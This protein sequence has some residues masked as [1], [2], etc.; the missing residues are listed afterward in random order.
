[1]TQREIHGISFTECPECSQ[2][3]GQ[4]GLARHREQAHGVAP[5]SKG[6]KPKALTTAAASM[7]RKAIELGTI[8]AADVLTTVAAPG[9]VRSGY[10][11]DNGDGSFTVTDAGRARLAGK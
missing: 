7:L 11:I 2:P 9:L 8:T 1:M 6:R 3:V 5:T 4:R 10:L